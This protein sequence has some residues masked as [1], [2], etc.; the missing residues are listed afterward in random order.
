MSRRKIIKDYKAHF[1]LQDVPFRMLGLHD[2]EV[3]DWA[4]QLVKNCNMPNVSGSY[5]RYCDYLSLTLDGMKPEE[6]ARECGL[7]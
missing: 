7:L 2:K 5:G 1:G 4:V 3:I 6:A